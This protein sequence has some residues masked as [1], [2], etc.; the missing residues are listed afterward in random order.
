MRRPAHPISCKGALVV[1]Y[2]HAI[3]YEASSGIS[4]LIS[5]TTY[6]NECSG[7]LGSSALAIE[8]S[9][10]ASLWR[11]SRSSVRDQAPKRRG[12]AAAPTRC[13]PTLEL[14]QNLLPAHRRPFPR[15]DAPASRKTI[16]RPLG[17]CALRLAPGVLG[18][19]C[20]P[21]RAGARKWRLRSTRVFF[22]LELSRDIG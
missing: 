3:I 13:S 11:L 17:E 6:L 21:G 18:P 12:H 10:V 14:T 19:T 16:A 22:A 9:S 4:I 2:R 15:A 5:E 20:L 7:V 8:P 1:Y